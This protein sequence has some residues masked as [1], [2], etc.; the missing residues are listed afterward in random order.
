MDTIII[1][2]HYDGKQIRLDEP[3]EL[4]PNSRLLV[5]VLPK[6]DINEEREYWHHL[7]KMTL[8][9]AYDEDEIEYSVDLIIKDNPE[10]EG[11]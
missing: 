2:A 8:A 10:Y 9:N 4:E 11:T 1:P 7:S 3:Y 5:T 6:Q